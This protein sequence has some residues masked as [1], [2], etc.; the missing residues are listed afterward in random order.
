M[1]EKIC[2][3]ALANSGLVDFSCEG[4]Y[5]QWWDEHNSCCIVKTL[6]TTLYTRR[7]ERRKTPAEEKTSAGV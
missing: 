4:E 2:P 7:L 6:V 3:F 1:D 5:C